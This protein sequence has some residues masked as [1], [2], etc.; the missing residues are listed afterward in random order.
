[1]SESNPEQPT[2]QDPAEPNKLDT[3]V[4]TAEQPE[5]DAVTT[6]GEAVMSS[7]DALEYRGSNG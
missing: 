7:G 6:G 2:H 5:P 4:E 1:M 3:E